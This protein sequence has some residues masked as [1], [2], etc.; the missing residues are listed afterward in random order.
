MPRDATTTEILE[1][2]LALCPE[3][4]PPDIRAQRAP[5]ID[6]IRP[7][8]VEVTCGLRPMRVGGIRM[9]IEHIEGRQNQS[10]IPMLLNYG[11]GPSGYEPSWG[12]AKA[13]LGLLEGALL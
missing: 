2:C 11:Y 4:A 10:K 5:T 12:S 7:L 1:R 8:I 13:A 6:D 3:L 9:E